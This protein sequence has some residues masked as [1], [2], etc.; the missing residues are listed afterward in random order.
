MDGRC[1]AGSIPREREFSFLFP[2]AAAW[3][4]DR[5]GWLADRTLPTLTVASPRPG[6]NGTLTHLR[7]GM[8]D[9]TSGLDVTS[10]HVV[11][12]FAVDV[13]P[14]FGGPVDID[15]VDVEPAREGVDDLG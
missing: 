10:F 12:D 14:T 3:P 1:I 6:V 2:P 9:R 8:T 7:I 4:G 13:H 5:T 15:Y 11:A